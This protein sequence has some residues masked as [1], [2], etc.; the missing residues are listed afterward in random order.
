MLGERLEKYKVPVYLVNTGW[1]GGPYG[2]GSRI[3]VK[4]TRAMVSAAINGHLD[5]VQ[6]RPHPIFKIL[7]PEAVPEVPAQILAEADLER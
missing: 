4:Y 2:V 7:L 6:F 3:P 5:A 1:S